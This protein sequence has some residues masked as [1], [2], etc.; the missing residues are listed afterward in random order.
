MNVTSPEKFRGLAETFLRV[1][2]SISDQGIQGYGVWVAPV[3]FLLVVF[4]L[5]SPSVEHTNKTL[6]PIWDWVANNTNTQATSFGNVHPTFFDLFK[7]WISTDVSITMLI[8]IGS[9]LVLRKALETRAGALAELVGA[10][11]KYV[12]PSMLI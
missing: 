12:A 7:F 3:T 4:H 11:G 6:T 9:R 10:D 5:N 8:W 2:L 1:L